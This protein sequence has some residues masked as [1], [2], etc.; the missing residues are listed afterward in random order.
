MFM[1]HIQSSLSAAQTQGWN[2]AAFRSDPI[3]GTNPFRITPISHSFLNQIR[4]SWARFK[5][6]Q[7]VPRIESLLFAVCLQPYDY[8]TYTNIS[9]CST[10]TRVEL[11]RVWERSYP[12]K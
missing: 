7:S 3:R 4:R 1:L 5:A 2:C 9:V 8:A 12:R 10:N 6:I 11:C